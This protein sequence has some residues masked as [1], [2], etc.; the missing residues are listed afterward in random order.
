MALLKE[1]VCSALLDHLIAQ[2]EEA[3]R[4]RLLSAFNSNPTAE[5]LPG[6]TESFAPLCLERSR[7]SVVSSVADAWA[8]TSEIENTESSLGGA[9]SEGQQ[10][11]SKSVLVSSFKAKRM[12]E[13]ARRRER[14]SLIKRLPTCVAAAADGVCAASGEGNGKV[15]VVHGQSHKARP[16]GATIKM[17]RRL[18]RQGGGRVPEWELP[19][20]THHRGG[21][22]RTGH[23]FQS[24]YAARVPEPPKKEKKVYVKSAWNNF[25]DSFRKIVVAQNPTM[26][27]GEIGRELGRRWSLLNAEDRSAFKDP[28]K[29][30]E[31][32]AKYE[33]KAGLS[34]ALVVEPQQRSSAQAAKKRGFS[35]LTS[36]SR[37]NDE[38]DDD[39]DDT[40]A[41]DKELAKES[42]ESS[43][44]GEDESEQKSSDDDDF[45][46]INGKKTSQGGERGSKKKAARI[47]KDNGSKSATGDTKVDMN[48]NALRRRL[49]KE[50]WQCGVDIS[51]NGKRDY[52]SK[53][54][55][56]LK[57]P[58]RWVGLRV[59]RFYPTG[60]NDKLKKQDGKLVAWMPANDE[61]EDEPAL[62]RMVHADGDEEDLEEAE[63]R[64]A[65]SA[66]DEN[67]DQP[68][69][70][71]EE[72]TEDV[73]SVAS[74]EEQEEDNEGSDSES[75]DGDEG[76]DEDEGNDEDESDDD[77]LPP[78]WHALPE[79]IKDRV[80]EVVWVKFSGKDPWWPG[81]I[82]HPTG[83]QGA[84]L[85]RTLKTIATKVLALTACPFIYR[86]VLGVD[87]CRE[88]E[89]MLFQDLLN[90]LFLFFAV[91]GVFLR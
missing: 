74:E 35:E 69:E 61:E 21:D 24:G 48:D 41:V 23:G 80:M 55:L 45:E 53:K 87:W 22:S 6:A 66:F 25:C 26:S 59:R 1:S 27:F 44:N 9:C 89:D 84:L 34:T 52:G 7:S 64:Q 65:I 82:Y 70:D 40:S 50:G 85:E 31:W 72:Q 77:D 14:L 13:E 54:G 17:L 47:S 38:E 39:K 76:D 16:K 36:T 86:H 49:T 46:T 90:S 78:E 33:S 75:I 81:L 62:W 71:I 28:A 5:T 8:T 11:V 58:H 10:V 2:K 19:P 83:V 79:T 68:P 88:I 37:D 51:L 29:G 56:E 32:A 60:R 15:N 20:G 30:L 4:R 12:G 18:A 67:M 57:Q 91:S 63:V 3:K 42:K 73:N 43:D